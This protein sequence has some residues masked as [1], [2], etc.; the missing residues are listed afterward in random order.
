MQQ[1]QLDV[2]GAEINA[3]INQLQGGLITVIEFVDAI[4]HKRVYLPNEDALCGLL[5]PFT[6]LRYPTAEELAVMDARA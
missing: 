2:V 5:C 3:L 6:G 1:Q 4:A